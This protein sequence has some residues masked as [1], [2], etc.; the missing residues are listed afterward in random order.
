MEH[1]FGVVHFSFLERQDHIAIRRT[2]CRANVGLPVLAVPLTSAVT[3]WNQLRSP[4]PPLCL[5]C[6]INVVGQA[7]AP[8]SQG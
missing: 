3:K 6:F 1:V 2:G 4:K 7:A 8:L 5:V